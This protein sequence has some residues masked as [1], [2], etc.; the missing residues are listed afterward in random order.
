MK[1][2]LGIFYVSIDMVEEQCEALAWCLKKLQFVPTRVECLHH[3]F[4]YEYIGYSPLFKAL[5]KGDKVPEY[6]IVMSRLEDSVMVKEVT[7]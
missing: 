2:N 6:L 7:P 4:Q 3:R 1:H 5:I